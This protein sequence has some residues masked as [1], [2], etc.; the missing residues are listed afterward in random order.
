VSP[1]HA[2]PDARCV[3]V[4]VFSTPGAEPAP[5][6][7]ANAR[8][9]GGCRVYYR[10]VT[11]NEERRLVTRRA[12]HLRDSIWRGPGG[13]H[14]EH[15][16]RAPRA[17]RAQAPLPE[18]LARAPPNPSNRAVSS[19]LGPLCCPIVPREGASPPPPHGSRHQHQQHRRQQ[20]M[21]RG[22]GARPSLLARGDELRAHEVAQLA[23]VALS[24]LASILGREARVAAERWQQVVAQVGD[25]LAA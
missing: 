17:P 6:G 16:E 22:G 11:T 13:P 2:R 24:E 23:R 18:R 21:Q 25:E 9:R 19:L 3:C 7:P 1:R 8:C 14:S 12:I 15:S 4:I 10:S 20:H 5:E